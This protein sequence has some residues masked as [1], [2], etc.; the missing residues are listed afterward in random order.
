MENLN[1]LDNITIK[2]KHT[3]KNL[4][5]A[6]ILIIIIVASLI[7][8]FGTMYKFP[9]NTLPNSIPIN[10]KLNSVIG[11]G[12][13]RYFNLTK[14]AIFTN[15]TLLNQL[16]RLNISQN[17][18]TRGIKVAYYGSNSLLELISVLNTSSFKTYK[19]S[20]L[21]LEKE[22][23]YTI[24]NNTYTGINYSEI[25]YNNKGVINSFIIFAYYKNY[26][27][28]IISTGNYNTSSVNN[29]IFPTLVNII[30]NQTT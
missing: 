26:F 29:L 18:I 2:P 30:E 13:Y 10:I 11:T 24:K 1:N 27:V 9:S 12:I 4:T 8:I 22:K 14:P 3:K 15:I 20:L 19:N 6:I 17:N 21:Y 23:F 16:Y 7:Y 5:I 25:Y 28:S